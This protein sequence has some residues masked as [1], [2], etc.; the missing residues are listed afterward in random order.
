MSKTLQAVKLRNDFYRD[1]FRRV[2]LVMIL[3]FILNIILLVLLYFTNTRPTQVIYFAVT[4]Q[5][6]LI[7]LAPLS[8]PVLGPAQL[9]SWVT[10]NVPRIYSLDYVH[11]RD[12]MRDVRKYFTEYGWGQF[13]QAFQPTLNKII[14]GKYVVSAAVTDVPYVVGMAVIRGVYSWK[15]QVPL[16]VTFRQGDQAS[17]EDVIWELVVQR[18]N[19]ADSDQLVGIS[20]IVQTTGQ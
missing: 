6:E 15:I 4:Q 19:N 5:G 8:S 7:K 2:T 1:N 17:T 16:K 11:F 20:Q 18:V 9:Q 10:Q 3:S 12:Q 14:S 13:T